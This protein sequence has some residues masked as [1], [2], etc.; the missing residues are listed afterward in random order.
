MIRSNSN[1][2]RPYDR[3]NRINALILSE[4]NNILLKKEI[5][6]R[7]SEAENRI[8]SLSKVETSRDL[9]TAQVYFLVIPEKFR[10]QTQK[11][12]DKITPEVQN[13]LAKKLQTKSKPRLKFIYDVGQYNAFSVEKI[14]NQI[15]K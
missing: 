9:R 12:L 6:A 11:L 1:Q 14:L 13:L 8:V 3:I 15:K 2:K 4:L 5:F 10:A 7:V